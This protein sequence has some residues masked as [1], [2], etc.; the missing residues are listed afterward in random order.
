MGQQPV[1]NPEVLKRTGTSHISAHLAELYMGY[2]VHV[3]RK[4]R[5]GPIRNLVLDPYMGHRSLWG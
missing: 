1:T 2:L 4:K 5:I 3:L